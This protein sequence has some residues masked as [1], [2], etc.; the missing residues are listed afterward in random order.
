[1]EFSRFE[2]SGCYRSTPLKMNLV[3]KIRLRRGTSATYLYYAD[4]SRR[5]NFNKNLAFE[6]HS[7]A[8]CK[9]WFWLLKD[10]PQASSFRLA[11][12]LLKKF[13]YQHANLIQLIH[14]SLP[15]LV[16]LYFINKTWV[17]TSHPE[18]YML[19]W[20][21]PPQACYMHM[22]SFFSPQHRPYWS[23]TPLK[24]WG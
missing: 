12:S 13:W 9:R 22:P 1:V 11:A 5:W 23:T 7:L 15:W 17:T 24:K 16:F 19:G 20:S 8:D 4:S 2:F 6:K 14:G 21:A 3:L 10:H 18:T